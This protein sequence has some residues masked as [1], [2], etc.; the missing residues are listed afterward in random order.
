VDAV[1]PRRHFIDFNRLALEALLVEVSF[2]IRRSAGSINAELMTGD[3]SA[4]A[5]RLA[6]LMSEAAQ[7]IARARSLAA[8][9]AQPPARLSVLIARFVSFIKTMEVIS[10]ESV[11]PLHRRDVILVLRRV[12]SCPKVQI[13][14]PVHPLRLFGEW[15]AKVSAAAKPHPDPLRLANPPMPPRLLLAG[16]SQTVAPTTSKQ[17]TGTVEYCSPASAVT[18]VAVDRTDEPR[19]LT[20]EMAG[21]P[22]DGHPLLDR[23]PFTGAPAPGPIDQNHRLRFRTHP[24]ATRRRSTPR[25]GTGKAL[26]CPQSTFAMPT[27]DVDRRAGFT[28]GSTSVG[29]PRHQC[30]SAR[31][32]EIIW[33]M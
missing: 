18:T 27:A 31:V 7:I 10:L 11:K 26:P 25:P 16:I 20:A 6:A 15:L 5:A 2:S 13:G 24:D 30:R 21:R 3:A 23:F 28:R 14:A 29:R 9:D 4:G 1:L 22:R 32:I 17:L 19:S 33:Q 8:E 12:R